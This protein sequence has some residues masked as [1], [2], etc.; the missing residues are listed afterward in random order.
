LIKSS[1]KWGAAVALLL[2]G[3]LLSACGGPIAAQHW[4]ALTVAGDMVYAISGLP[5][6][7]YMLDA[8][9][10]VQKGMFM[11]SAT[12][13][14]QTFY[15]SPVTVGDETPLTAGDETAFVGFAS[16]QDKYA[17]LFAFN[18]ATGQELWSVAADDLILAAPAY[19]DGT[20]YFGTSSGRVYAVDTTA[21]AVKVGWPFQ[22]KEAIWGSP[23]VIEER[24]YVPAMDHR[25]YCLNAK[26]GEL[27]WEFSA[28]GALAA[29]PSP[30]DGT[31]YQ[32]AFDGRVYAIEAGSGQQVS[33]FDFKAGN[34]IWSEVLV[35]DGRLYV[36]SLE[37]KLYA[38]DAATGQVQSGYPYQVPAPDYIRAAPAR[39]EDL[40]IIATSS[41]QVI[42]LNN[43][44]GQVVGAPWSIGTQGVS[45]L[46]TPVVSGERVYVMLSTG[47][48]Q[49][50]TV[51]EGYLATGW[52]FAPPATQ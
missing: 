28:G 24:V 6:K 4:P 15:W 13:K 33:G 30:N 47:Q 1:R 20:V 40:V 25:L 44:S 19:A 51:V 39:I 38:L 16:P 8:E 50:F 18:P 2:V 27:V 35:D 49:T 52:S 32:G 12:F 5:Q 14:G 41:G 42:A 31:L 7:V 10:G 43:Q 34:W 29:H 37:G 23:L 45:I 11:P 36:T 22:A 46:T 17:G 26:T 9:T 3:V 48:V 21:H